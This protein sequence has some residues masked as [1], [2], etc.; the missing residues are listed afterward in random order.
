M[1]PY[2]SVRARSVVDDVMIKHRSISDTK[3]IMANFQNL[4]LRQ[5]N[6]IFFTGT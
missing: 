6:A 4:S 3:R 2:T 1:V 5:K